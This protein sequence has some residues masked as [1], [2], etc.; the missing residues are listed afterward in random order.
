MSAGAY[1][2]AEKAIEAELRIYPG[3][4]ELLLNLATIYARTG[5]TAEAR[6]LYANVLAQRDVLMDV[7]ADKVVGSHAIATMGLKQIEAVQISSR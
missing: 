3:R 6:V 5:R 4:P 1:A 7:S 2:Q